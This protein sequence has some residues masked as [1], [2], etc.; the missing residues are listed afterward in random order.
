MASPGGL[1]RVVTLKGGSLVKKCACLV[2]LVLL[3]GS[4]SSCARSPQAQ[5]ARELTAKAT[6]F[7]DLLGKE[8]FAT[9][10]QDFDDVMTRAMPAPKLEGAWKT[11]V[12]QAGPFQRQVRTRAARDKGFD[13]I[14]VTCRFQK[15]T[16]DV[17]VVF[18]Q[19][20]QITG[21]WF[22]PSQ[23]A[24][25]EYEPPAYVKPDSFREQEVTVGTGEWAVPG[26]LSVPQGEGPFPALVLV[27]GSGPHDRDE[28]IG[29]NKPF[30]D[31]A[32]G[33]ASRGIAVLRY[34]KR[35]KH[36]TAQLAA[37][38]DSITVKEETIDDAMAAVSVLREAQGVDPKRIYVLGHSLGGMLIP[39]IGAR[40]AHIAGFIILAGT[41]RPLED[42]YLEQVSYIFSL[43]GTVSESEKAELDKI[44]AQV[45]K[46]K[47]PELSPATPAAELPLG[48]SATY[49]LDLRG[50]NPPEAAKSLKRPMLVLQGG[51]DYQV[52]MTDFEGWQKALSGREEVQ[53]KLYPGLNH[54]FVTGEGRSTPAE[55]EKAGHVAESV[56][57]DIANWVNQP[58]A[59]E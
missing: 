12:G 7:V 18:N 19:Q 29:P 22:A 11:V 43:D 13:I 23:E 53:F 3:V 25:A 58:L 42:V 56:I 28:T 48:V 20:Q 44:R 49:W 40:D 55:Y 45:A 14:V 46:L 32:G 54:L 33:L 15:A 10:V 57:D 9:A 16:I 24:A 4:S 26:T 1:R 51:R 31:L 8:D 6:E 34:E 36:H 52:T 37:V 47:D 30:R 41:T 35:T 27:H 2:S 59:P 21:L 50:Y 5:Q 38:K 39:R 17:K